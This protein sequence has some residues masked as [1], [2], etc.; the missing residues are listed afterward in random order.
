MGI[1][2]DGNR[3]RQGADGGRGRGAGMIVV[4]GSLNMDLVVPVAA[5]PRPGETVL[6][7][8]YSKAPGGKGANQAVA[9]ARAGASVA[10]AGCVGRDEDGD[11]LLERLAAADVDGRAIAA[12]AAPTGLALVAV[13]EGGANPGEN[14]PGENMIIAASGANLAARHSMVTDALL[15]ACSTLLLQLELPP[16][17]SFALARRARAAGCRVVLNAAPAG[18]IET[19]ALDVLVMNRGE[20][21]DVAA[22]LGLGADGAEEIACRLAE[23][24]RLTA[25]VTLGADGALAASPQGRWRIATLP[26]AA[27]DSTGAGDA[28]TGTLAAAID[29]GMAFADALARASVAGA[30]TCLTPGAMPALPTAAAIDARLGELA[31]AQPF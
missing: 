25:V 19:D 7:P 24:H 5:L 15:A 23:R 30:L 6:A 13:A 4:F 27:A 3:R 10:M 12:V 22:A 26:V 18:A 1:A 11:R 28:F 16:D 8:G 31:A 9:A 21:L 20:A 2:D 29:A 17:E 14:M